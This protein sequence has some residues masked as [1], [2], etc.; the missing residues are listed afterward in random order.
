MTIFVYRPDSTERQRMILRLATC[1]LF[2]LSLCVPQLQAQEK[3]ASIIECTPANTLRR[4]KVEWPKYTPEKFDGDTTR[5]Q[6]Q[7]VGEQSFVVL[8]AKACVGLDQVQGFECLTY[9]FGNTK[10]LDVMP[11]VLQVA[12]EDKPDAYQKIELVKS[13]PLGKFPGN[14]TSQ[15]YRTK[16]DA[17][18]FRYARLHMDN[19]KSTWQVVVGQM[20]MTAAPMPVIEQPKPQT[21]RK[22]TAAKP[23]PVASKTQ[24]MPKGV[25]SHGAGQ[26]VIDFEK[27]LPVTYSKANWSDY[28]AERY[29]D[30]ATRIRLKEVSQDSH[31]IFDVQRL[32]TA[33]NVTDLQLA[34][35]GFSQTWAK[36]SEY[37]IIETSAD[38]V[39][40]KV[41]PTLASPKI[42][43]VPSGRSLVYLR[44]ANATEPFRYI[45]VHLNKAKSAW[46]IGLT[47]LL[48]SQS[49]LSNFVSIME[50]K[51]AEKPEAQAKQSQTFDLPAYQV[52]TAYRQPQLLKLMQGVSFVD[53]DVNIKNITTKD[54]N[55]QKADIAEHSYYG[56]RWQI[57][58]QAPKAKCVL[59]RLS[60]DLNQND[61]QDRIVLIFPQTF[62]VLD[63][64]L[65]GKAVATDRQGMAYTEV[66]LTDHIQ[67]AGQHELLIK[68]R[69]YYA[70]LKGGNVTM[71]IGAQYR[72]RRGFARA[73][74]LERRPATSLIHPFVWSDVTMQKLHA[75]VELTE[76]SKN[77]DKLQ[78]QITDKQNRT[79]LEKTVRINNGDKLQAITLD[80][81]NKLAK[82]DLGQPN[83]YQCRFNLLADNQIVDQLQ[84][85]FGYR[86]I[87]ARGE[88]I[89]LNGRK[90]Q[91]IGP[92]AHIGEWTRSRSWVDAGENYKAD[93]IN[94]FKT[95]L[96]HGINYGRFH[97]Q[98]FDRIFYEAADETGFLVVA[99][100]GLN[101][102]PK[103][104]LALEHVKAMTLQLRN[105]PAIVIWSG[106]N[107][108]EHWITPRPQA[109]EAFMV[110]VQETHK[111]YDPSRLVMH[112]GYGDAQGKID[113]YNIH[114][115]DSGPEFPLSLQWKGRTE[116]YNHLYSDNYTQFPPDG[117]KP[118]GI[119]EQLT[120]NTRLKLEY[121]FGD[122]MT[123]L[124]NGDSANHAKYQYHLAQLWRQA[125][126]TYREQNIA[127]LSPNFMYLD[128]AINSPFVKELSNELK[129][130]T[131]YW[132]S[133]N[134]AMTIG[135]NIRELQ[136]FEN[137]GHPFEGH[138]QL[139][140]QSEKKHYWQSRVDVSLNAS[141]SRTQLIEI[142][143]DNIDSE[144]SG[145][146]T[147]TL[148]D[149]AGNQ[150]YSMN[151]PV[152]IHPPISSRELANRVVYGLEVPQKIAALL[153][154]WQVQLKPIQTIADMTKLDSHATVIIGSHASSDQLLSH[155]M[156]VSEFVAAGGR[157]LM[158]DRQDLPE[159]FPSG[160]ALKQGLLNGATNG[161]I[162]SPNHSFFT[163]AI[164][165]MD[166]LDFAY[167][168]NGMQISDAN[169]YKP[170][171]GNFHV[172]VDGG[173]E[174]NDGILIEMIH[175]KGK[176]LVSQL[177]LEKSDQSPA[178]AKVLFNLIA[179]ATQSSNNNMQ[180]GKGY[181]LKGTDTYAAELLGKLGWEAYPQDNAAL[182]GLYVDDHAVKHHG[183]D[184]VISIAKRA[185][186]IHL[187]ITDQSNLKHLTAALGSH[188]VMLLE[189]T[190][191]NKSKKKS[192]PALL[193]AFVKRDVLFDGVSS[194]DMNWFT[195]PH[196]QS[197]S[198][199]A[200]D[201]W[202]VPM[203]PGV[204]AI[205]RHQG[206]TIL[207]DISQWN[208]VVDNDEQ[209]M[210]MLCSI[211]TQ[212]GIA[213]TGKTIRSG[214][215]NTI[216]TVNLKP[217][218]NVSAQAYLGPNMPS[219][220]VD[221]H[222]I[223]F[224]FAKA[225][226]NQPA[227]M[228]RLNSRMGTVYEGKAFMSDT[229]IDNFTQR[230]PTSVK[231]SLDRIH[232]SKIHFAHASS[233]NYK[234]KTWGHGFNVCQ[235]RINYYDGTDAT[236]SI[237][238]KNEIQDTRKTYTDQRHLLMGKQFLN[239]KNGDGEL[240]AI[241]I[242]SWENPS[243]EKKIASIE[244][245][246]AQNPHMDPML[247]ALSYTEFSGAYE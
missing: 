98:V 229:P 79:V 130:Q 54:Q 151:R 194:T 12:M 108:F 191:A 115:P 42:K 20:R 190:T 103:N 105:H 46:H 118:I 226:A 26:W 156:I 62:F 30:D 37:C 179:Y 5:L 57:E 75:S 195:K 235:Y 52:P 239:P 1:I 186:F 97:C 169:C 240:M 211:S 171:S 187:H 136:L 21:A 184:K 32:T 128:S 174:L 40:Y 72:Y 215:D 121:L 234:I 197:I 149:H 112:S 143:I 181:Y 223:T 205:N 35:Y 65:D 53:E 150:V 158:L 220:I 31:V 81:N 69:N 193:T 144:Q 231:I 44:L 8:D 86:D 113:I 17:P 88:D 99:E 165:P 233:F 114:Y 106:S 142:Q 109:T 139:A 91:L 10:S 15:V 24:A 13:T 166:Q 94:V 173:R 214:S 161:F 244:L 50:D 80:V 58:N 163:D 111:Q 63:V 180:W 137:T 138:V 85:T 14:R 167:W 3:D 76:V 218:C 104:D 56:V 153:K 178:A 126:R 213:L 127:L 7:P 147:V 101:H 110:Q 41:Q 117:V 141:E 120:P 160:I 11:L 71:P 25:I 238:L 232:A 227:T 124:R 102:R 9:S 83:L 140:V 125:V 89:L 116:Q 100:T 18:A 216:H 172:L 157:L 196:V 224:D 34:V 242:Y 93:L 192:P 68:V 185:R 204:M 237:K 188:P 67:S 246:T 189:N 16:P 45:R 168:G 247:F 207:T 82:W 122:K 164:L 228:I 245:I 176:Y 29:D 132:K 208:Q 236:I 175:G 43:S 61:T 209:R 60:L 27:N 177:L 129:P 221:L 95:M 78:I 134:P 33:D 146:L 203:Q 210:R 22:K 154:Q 145:S 148:F 107:E 133:L 66:D 77:A 200:D 230:T 48:V 217:Y 199:K 212:M 170:M 183:L 73:P 119:G 155:A 74:M 28:Q 90:I 4:E 36:L 198:F 201:H 38:G 219:G 131:V 23:K 6:F 243:P 152:K 162:R 135:K 59:Y 19:L 225:T 39:N 159:I 206:R 84:T 49:Q 222:G 96:S 47:K 70:A 64:Y 51:T 241:G 55:W 123:Y 202:S 2:I 87:Q 92:W 182:S